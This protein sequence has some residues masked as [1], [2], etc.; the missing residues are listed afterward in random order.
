METVS[1]FIDESGKRRSTVKAVN[2]E[3]D[4][5]IGSSAVILPSVNVGRG[6]IIA[7]GSI[8]NRDVEPWTMV[9]GVPAKFIK[10]LPVS[11]DLL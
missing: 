7:A 9:G 6:A 1:H 8:V 5:W 4:A 11:K 10:S 2:I 3:N